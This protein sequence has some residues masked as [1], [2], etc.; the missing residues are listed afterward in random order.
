[1]S[2]RRRRRLRGAENR[3]LKG[4]APLIV[5]VAALIAMV[6]VVPSRVPEDAAASGGGG[7]ATEVGEG[8]PATGWG[9]T[10]TAC[11]GPQVPDMS[12]SPPCFAFTGDNGGATS[13]GVTADTIRVAYRITPD[14]NLLKTLADLGGVQLDESNEEQARTAEGLVEYV[15]Q[16]F[17]LYGRR[18]ELVRYDGRGQLLQEFLGAGQDAATNDSIRVANEIGAFA[19]VTGLSQPYADGLYRNG[20]ISVGAPY[21]SREWFNSRRPYTWS[22]VPDCTAVADVSAEYTNKRLLG[23]DALFAGGDLADAPRTM[24]V[25]APNNLEYQQCADAFEGGLAAEGNALAVRLD[26]TLDVATLQSQA[27]NLLAQVKSE[28]VT[29]VSCACDP[30]M[31]M[32]LAEEATAQGYEPEWL[33]AG[34]GFIDLDLG[35]QIIANRAGDQWNR[36]FGGSRWATA[37]SPQTSEAHAAYRSVRQD[38][39]SELVDQIYAQIL[40]VALGI[41]MAGPNLT[42]ETF[43]TG[44]FAFPPSSGQAGRWD[45]SP[46][47]YTP[48][49]DL[50]EVWWDPDAVS[51]FNG[52]PGTWVDNGTRWNDGEIPSG[53]PEVFP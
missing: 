53:D 15:N 12:Y 42:P 6:A 47:H 41:Q 13:R 8:Q 46:E 21:M 31:Q 11:D 32:Y 1:M 27:A 20:V 16:N 10:V 39:P 25:I 51:P 49:V 3:A 14:D 29:S 2:G 44:L 9:T 36:A 30:I 52:K 35:G 7:T 5:L 50:R 48:V 17:Q 43:E 28:G 33:V 4:Y 38:E 45:F 24:A 19:D 22:N 18:I 37:Q 26:Y 40:T 23:R 34:V